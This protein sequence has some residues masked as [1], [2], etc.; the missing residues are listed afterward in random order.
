MLSA[1][2]LPSPPRTAQHL[3]DVEQA[4]ATVE[5]DRTRIIQSVRD[6]I[7][8]AALNTL[9]QGAIAGAVVALRK[10]VGFDVVAAAL[11]DGAAMSR[12]LALTAEARY[13]ACSAGAACGFLDLLGKL[14]DGGGCDPDSY[15]PENGEWI[16]SLSLSLLVTRSCLC[17]CS[18]A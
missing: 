13:S 7:G 3:V 9:V 15:N 10:P 5:A 11:G 14:W 1:T 6:G 4:E 16:S 18:C 8:T 12:V 17:F 2:H